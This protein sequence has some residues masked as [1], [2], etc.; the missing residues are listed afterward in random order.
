VK[1]HETRP[2][3]LSVLVRIH[4]TLWFGCSHHVDRV[5]NLN[6]QNTNLRE[7]YKLKSVTFLLAT[8]LRRSSDYSCDD[9]RKRRCYWVNTNNTITF[10]HSI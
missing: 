9:E 2:S 5:E 8:L 3:S 7:L 6:F 4:T 1:I 10:E